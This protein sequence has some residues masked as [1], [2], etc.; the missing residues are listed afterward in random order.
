MIGR[1]N[2]DALEY[3]SWSREL[4]FI[5]KVRDIDFWSKQTIGQSLSTALTFVSGDKSY[6]FTFVSG[7]AD[8]GQSS[9]FDNVNISLEESIKNIV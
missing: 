4:N 8:I 6:T 5:I 9:L 3:H 2:N 7:G 1:G